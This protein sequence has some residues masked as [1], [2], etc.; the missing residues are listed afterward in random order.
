MKNEKH[1]TYMHRT[2]IQMHEL[3]L[4]ART[5]GERETNGEQV[6]GEKET[7]REIERE[8]EGGVK[9]DERIPLFSILLILNALFQIFII[10][11]SIQATTVSSHVNLVSFLNIFHLS[12]VL[13]QPGS[14]CLVLGVL[15]RQFYV[16]TNDRIMSN[17]ILNIKSETC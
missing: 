15:I 9:E 5:S 12:D 4:I 7:E 14:Q 1:I 6:R 17:T 13:Q 2:N 10:C 11:L 16:G 8:R 3:T